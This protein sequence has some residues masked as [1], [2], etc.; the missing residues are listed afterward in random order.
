MMSHLVDA[1]AKVFLDASLQKCHEIRIKAHHFTFNLIMFLLI[2]GIGGGF[3]YYCYTTKP[4][5]EET[6]YKIMQ[7]Q[8]YILSK[9]RFFQEQ[10]E[11]INESAS[12]ITGL[13]SFS[14]DKWNNDNTSFRS[15]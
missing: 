7:D 3:L 9:I 2:I 5:K 12:P 4:T 10:Q 11:K 1:E 6:G 15:V 13:P 8:E 14:Q